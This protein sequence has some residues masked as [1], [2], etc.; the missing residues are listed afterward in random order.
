[1]RLDCHAKV[2]DTQERKSLFEKMK[3]M[4]NAYSEIGD[5]VYASYCGADRRLADS[6]IAVFEQY[7]EHS[8]KLKS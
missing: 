4:A 8:I 1:M 6:I 2:P 7:G 5:C 3:Q